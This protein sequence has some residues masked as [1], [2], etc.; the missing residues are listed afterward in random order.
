MDHPAGAAVSRR[1][2]I[3]GAVAGLG[4]VAVAGCS[5]PIA[6]GIA[7]SPLAPGAI[8]YWNLFGG[9][10]GVRMQQMEDGYRRTHPDTPLQ[11]ITLAWGNPYYTKLSLAT[12][13]AKPPDVAVSHLTR[14]KTLVQADLLEELALPDLARHGMTPDKFNQRAW[15]AGLVGGKAYAIP[16]DTHPFVLFY[17]TK[18]CK[19]AGLLDAAGNLT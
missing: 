8:D 12:V 1:S 13:G 14:M 11:A 16:I 4:A 19:D 3:R 7:N 5:S 6:A 9:G 18:I 2:L 17:N 15:Q 10:D